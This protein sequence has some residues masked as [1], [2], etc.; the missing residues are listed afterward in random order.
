MSHETQI[1]GSKRPQSAAQKHEWSRRNSVKNTADYA[2]A[3]RDLTAT[4]HE[5]L[6]VMATSSKLLP[7]QQMI[8][9][10]QVNDLAHQLATTRMTI[11]RTIRR[12]DQ[13][14]FVIIRTA[15]NGKRGVYN[16]VWLGI[17]V[18]PSVALEKPANEKRL[19]RAYA[20]Q[21][22]ATM[23]QTL[24]ALKGRLK[25]MLQKTGEAAGDIWERGCAILSAFP[26][27]FEGPDEELAEL[28]LEAHSIL[29]ALCVV[30]EAAALE[31]HVTS[32]IHGCHTDAAP[33]TNTQDNIHKGIT[34]DGCETSEKNL[35]V[36][37][38]VVGGEDAVKPRK[39]TF[40]LKDALALL[41]PEDTLMMQDCYE[42]A[43]PNQNTQ[44]VLLDAYEQVAITKWLNLGGNRQTLQVFTDRFGQLERSV[45]LL[46][47]TDRMLNQNLAPVRNLHSYTMSCVAKC[48][49]GSFHWPAGIKSAAKRVGSDLARGQ[50]SYSKVA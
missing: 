5:L 23:T 20:C 27:R 43:M 22:R 39:D 26:K 47:L 48:M 6:K 4:E 37:M 1:Q 30:A 15:A 9:T 31:S 24:S 19:A 3:T 33:N 40:S 14:G 49:A 17:D 2:R 16:G 18:S 32:A 12:L 38:A 34:S 21:N 35:T 7:N 13:K 10:K 36:E 29:N 42:M 8:C 11:N 46:L 45:L 25:R 50:G 28:A 41:S 44:Q